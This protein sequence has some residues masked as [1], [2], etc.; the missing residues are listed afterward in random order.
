M[1]LPGGALQDPLEAGRAFDD[2]PVVV[3]LGDDGVII[4]GL[5]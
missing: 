4:V 1:P 2:S 3:K 5:F